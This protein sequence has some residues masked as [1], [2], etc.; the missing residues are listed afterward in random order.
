M[1]TWLIKT[2]E[3]SG[4]PLNGGRSAS[5]SRSTTFSPTAREVMILNC[6]L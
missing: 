2:P 4:A 6:V 1:C 3:A 5:L